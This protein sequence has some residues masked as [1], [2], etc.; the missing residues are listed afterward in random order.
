MPIKYGQVF[1]TAE[2]NVHLIHKEMMLN[3]NDGLLKKQGRP[4]SVSPVYKH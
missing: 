1:L 4:F 2:Y 3:K